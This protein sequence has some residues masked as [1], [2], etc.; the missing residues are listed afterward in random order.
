M[1]RQLK[2]D[3]QVLR[4]LDGRHR[5]GVGVQGQMGQQVGGGQVI[6]GSGSPGKGTVQLLYQDGGGCQG[7]AGQRRG[8]LALEGVVAVGRFLG[9]GW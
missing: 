3:D 6:L 4:A 5:V 8:G 2:E 7:R 1:S 9:Q